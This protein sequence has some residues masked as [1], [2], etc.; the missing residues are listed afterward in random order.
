MIPCAPVEWRQPPPPVAELK[1]EPQQAQAQ[2]P[3]YASRLKANPRGWITRPSW[4]VWVEPGGDDRWSQRWSTA[5][6]NA[7]Q[8]WGHHLEV[9]RVS[10]AKDAQLRLWRRRPPLRDGRASN[11]RAYLR[12]QQV[13]REGN[14]AALEPQVE[15]L[16]SPGLRLPV[17]QATA[18]HELGHG[19]GL[20]G[21]SDQATDVMAPSQG[22]TPLLQ[23]SPR[24]RQTLTWLLQQPSAVPVA[25]PTAMPPQTTS[26]GSAPPSGP[27]AD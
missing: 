26:P 5:V 2:A 21:H 3:G 19:F 22:A 18:L 25:P 23:L 15:V 9:V 7:L 17:L 27:R 4:C 16:L 1:R 11:G 8:E 12:L 24:D 10:D 20:W 6:S 14:A 13:K